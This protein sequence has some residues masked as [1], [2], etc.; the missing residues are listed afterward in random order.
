MAAI[1]T[2]PKP[3]DHERWVQC[4][5]RHALEAAE[6]AVSRIK[7]ALEG[8]DSAKRLADLEKANDELVDAQ[9]SLGGTMGLV[10]LGPNPKIADD[11]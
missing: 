5:G 7:S 1:V 8:G 6:A 3:E 11:K 10:T 2:Y 4:N 9:L